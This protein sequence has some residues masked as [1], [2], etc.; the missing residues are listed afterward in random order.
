M[1]GVSAVTLFIEAVRAGNT[2]R[3]TVNVNHTENSIHRIFLIIDMVDTVGD[4]N[5][6]DN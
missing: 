3:E 4:R 2:D 1:R 5:E 6:W